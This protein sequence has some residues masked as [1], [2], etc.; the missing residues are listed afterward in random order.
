MPYKV[1]INA[2]EAGSYEFEVTIDK[3][4]TVE[5]DL[6]AKTHKVVPRKDETA[7]DVEK[8][9]ADAKTNAGPRK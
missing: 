4:S 6:K 2:G 9:I 5:A 1:K 8:L 3:T 7:P